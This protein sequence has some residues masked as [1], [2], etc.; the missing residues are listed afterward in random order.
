MKNYTSIIF[1][2]LI[3][4]LILSFHQAT[5]QNSFQVR[6][7]GLNENDTATV[8]L[9]KNS[10]IYWKQ[11]AAGNSDKVNELTFDLADGKWAIVIDATGYTFPP[12][13][14]FDVPE[15]ST[16][17]VKLTPL[18][19]EDYYYVWQDD[20]SYV[21]HA[22]QTYISEPAK[23]VVLDKEVKVPHD[24]SSIELR[25]K[26]GIILSDDIEAWTVEDSYRIFKMFTNLPIG[27]FGEGGKTDP[28]TGENIRGI[29]KLTKD[30]Q[31]R[32][33][34]IS[35]EDGIK[36]ATISQAAFHYAEPQIVTVDGIKGKFYSKRLYHAVVNFMSD[37]ANDE[38][39]INHI[40]MERFG[41]RFM[42]ADQETEVLM[43]EDASNFQEFFREEKIEILSMFEELPEGFHKQEGLK[44]LVRRINGQPNPIYPNA[45]AIAW[46]GLHTI[47]FMDI[48]FSGSFLSGTR[49]LILHEKTHFLWAYTFDD[50]VKT[51]WIELGGWFQD[52]TSASG[53]STYNTTES[54]SAYG[55]AGGP[56]EDM[57]ET[58]SYY[59]EDPDKLMA[60]SVRK[61]EFIRDRVMHGTRY[62]AQFREDLTFMVYNLFPDYTYPGKV[63]KVE[64]QVKGKPEEE[65]EVT[66]RLTLHSNDL[67]FDGASGAYVRFASS[68]GTIHDIGFAPEN[69]HLD[70]ILVGTTIFNKHE[71]NGY[72]TM[73][74]MSVWDKVGNQRYENTSTIGMK[75][76]IENPLEDIVP[77]R[78]NYDL[79]MENVKKTFYSHTN[80]PE[81]IDRELQAIKVTY[82]FYDDIP[83]VYSESN[84]ILSTP[85]RPGYESYFWRLGGS[86]IIDSTRNYSNGY[87][88][89][90]YIEAFLK[91]EEYMPSGYYSITAMGA[92]DMAGNTSHINFSKDTSDVYISPHSNNSFKDV[93]D[94][95]YTKTEFPDYVKPEIDLNLITVSATPTNPI[96]PDG[97]TRV[98]LTFFVRDLSDFPGRESGVSGI[99]FFF[100]DPIGIDHNTYITVSN[101]YSSVP[102]NNSDWMF[103]SHNFLLPKGSPPG[104]WGFTGANVTDKAGNSRRYSFIEY[105]RFDVIESEI[106]LEEPLDASIN[107]KYINLANVDNIDISI[108]CKPSAGLKYVYTIYSL[109]G[110]NVVRGEGLMTNDSLIIQGVN[111]QGV[112]DGILK[113]TVQLVDSASQIIA[114]KTVEYDKDTQRPKAYYTRTNLQN[115]GHSNLDDVVIQ[116]VFDPEDLGG[117][118][119]MAI[120]PVLPDIKSTGFS[121]FIITGKLEDQPP[122]DVNIDLSAFLNRVI[123]TTLTLTDTVHNEGDPLVSYYLV[124]EDRLISVDVNSDFD[125][126]G[127]PDLMD[128]CPAAY[129]TSYGCASQIQTVSICEG[130]SYFGW[131]VSGEY[132][133][134]FKDIYG[135][136]SIV[137]VLLTVNPAFQPEVIVKGDT[138]IAAGSF[139]SY[140]WYANG[141]LISI[142]NTNTFIATE[143]G[144]YQLVVTDEYGCS[145]TSEIVSL[146]ITGNDMFTEEAFEYLV[147]PNPTDE[148]FVVKIGTNTNERVSFKFI[149][150]VGQILEARIVHS[151]E[152]QGEERFQVGHLTRGVYILIISY[153]SHQAMEK[154]VIY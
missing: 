114:T 116:I 76:Y 95:I 51:D 140:L 86:A 90:K 84:F 65:K 145:Q 78:W 144:D 20:D 136:D 117:T 127:F 148:F 106:V 4:T 108:S 100:R 123:K 109:M 13:T 81:G 26:Y 122:L 74:S 41:V 103:Y 71:K 18:L 66:I 49:R 27:T 153:G 30:E 93:R 10:D 11:M 128:S 146:V 5:G 91:I 111:T 77:P 68:I 63:K 129:G 133:R 96:Y 46:T 134:I 60:V 125:G 115:E 83:F 64:I 126:D 135:S 15:N 8:I 33:L 88:S 12:A 138:L 44:Y 31:F 50:Q 89:V 94:S 48:S 142:T 102:A 72:W 141:N 62:I 149:N 118:Y 2:L 101:Y 9:R 34:T 69:G 24:Y 58:V 1:H 47:E 73:G 99:E 119:A 120:E 40:A 131:T 53:W 70:S 17:L 38:G 14:S 57:A 154:I 87:K 113:L 7:E 32:D 85:D 139:N 23:I 25:N 59:L 98:D 39:F 37:F 107:A 55:H 22:T 110:G 79:T 124:L 52:P 112:L 61:Y 143:N 137:T 105:V 104:K 152:I 35:Y 42:R 150:P 121:G 54:V 97:E 29:I 36:V 6:L 56:D 45:A 80:Y 67:E 28:A 132:E 21:G 147:Y 130:E 82:S 3:I 43:S 16:A 19:N 75:L 151:K 92:H